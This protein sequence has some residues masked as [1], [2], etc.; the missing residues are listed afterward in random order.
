MIQSTCG[1]R[2][3]DNEAAG[4]VGELA[5]EAYSVVRLVINK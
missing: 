1:G 5:R 3:E 4:C 2:A